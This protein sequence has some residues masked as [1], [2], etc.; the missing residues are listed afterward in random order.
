M[1]H[2]HLHSSQQKTGLPQS[3]FS[4]FFQYNLP[5][6]LIKIKTKRYEKSN[7]DKRLNVNL[8]NCI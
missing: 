8:F 4:L 6:S 5:L 3:L 7:R 1:T 2:Y